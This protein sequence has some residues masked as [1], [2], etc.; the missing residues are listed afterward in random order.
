MGEE[1]LAGHAE[2][3]A[4]VDFFRGAVKL[5]ELDDGAGAVLGL[6]QAGDE[7]DFVGADDGA[8]LFEAEVGFEPGGEDVVVLAP[9]AGFV[10]AFD[11]SEE[12][13]ALLFVGDSVEGEEIGDVAG[14]EADSAEFESAD[15]GVG[16]ADC[17]SG[18]FPGDA[19]GLAEPS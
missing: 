8:G 6:K 3:D 16:G 4:A 17:V 13:V 2:G 1:V 5:A 9:P 14:F 18:D 11:E 10:G 19:T 7:L 15:F 12:R